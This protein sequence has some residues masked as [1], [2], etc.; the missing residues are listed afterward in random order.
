M[1]LVHRPPLMH[2]F[3]LGF[4]RPSNREPD[5]V[6]DFSLL[7]LSTARLSETYLSC[8]KVDGS[9]GMTVKATLFDYFENNNLKLFG[10]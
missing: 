10:I 8:A 4:L 5:C 9:L 2:S 1:T 6:S 7:L 3:S